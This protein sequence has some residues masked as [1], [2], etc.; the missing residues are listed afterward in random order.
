M[1]FCRYEPCVGMP[2]P[3]PPLCEAWDKT[4]VQSMRQKAEENNPYHSS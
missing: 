4:M 1:G 3:C 2:L